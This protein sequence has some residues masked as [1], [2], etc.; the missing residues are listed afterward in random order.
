MNI[1]LGYLQNQY[2]I[3]F[4]F[5]YSQR[6]KAISHRKLQ[7]AIC[8]NNNK[9]KQQKEAS[10]VFGIQGVVKDPS[11]FWAISFDVFQVFCLSFDGNLFKYKTF[12][13]T[14]IYNMYGNSNVPK[15][16][17]G[18]I[19]NIAKRRCF[20]L[21]FVQGLLLGFLDLSVS[22]GTLFATRHGVASCSLKLQ[23]CQNYDSTSVC[24][25]AAVIHN[26]QNRL[27]LSQSKILQIVCTLVLIYSLVEIYLLLV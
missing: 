1:L 13:L 22:P 4:R 15:V 10:C 19:F 11:T 14:Y 25:I 6:S 7:I 3:L 20:I 21:S 18:T 12:L 8:T 24:N 5:V 2:S 17:A 16:H 27:G 9:K 23:I 26:L